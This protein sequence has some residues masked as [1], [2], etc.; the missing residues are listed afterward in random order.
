MFAKGRIDVL[1]RLEPKV[2]VTHLYSFMHLNEFKENLKVNINIQKFN[3]LVITLPFLCSCVCI[4]FCVHE[5]R[6][7]YVC[8]YVYIYVFVCDSTSYSVLSNSL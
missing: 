7:T 2:L 3:S 1:F 8:M 6:N 4:S 5:V